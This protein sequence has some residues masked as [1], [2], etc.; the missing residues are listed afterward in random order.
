M[1]E[2]VDKPAT[3]THTQSANQP[4]AANVAVDSL[5]RPRQTLVKG[6]AVVVNA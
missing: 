3:H 1:G 4:D 6:I 2:A 5:F